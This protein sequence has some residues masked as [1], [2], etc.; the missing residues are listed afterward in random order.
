[1]SVSVARRVAVASVAATGIAL[2][3]RDRRDAVTGAANGAI[4][5]GRAFGY[6]AVVSLDYKYRSVQQCELLEH[7]RR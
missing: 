6:G 3:D 4:R 7:D 5:F 2:A 1:M